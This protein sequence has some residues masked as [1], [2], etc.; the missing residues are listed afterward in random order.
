MSSNAIARFAVC[1]CVATEPHKISAPNIPAAVN[2]AGAHNLA[3]PHDARMFI[4]SPHGTNRLATAHI[5]LRIM[6]PLR[7]KSKSPKQ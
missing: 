2:L 4:G 1:A 6:A 7:G 3:L 5:R